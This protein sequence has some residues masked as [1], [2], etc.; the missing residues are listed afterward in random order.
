MSTGE[1]RK[2][3]LHTS[4]LLRSLCILDTDSTI[5][6]SGLVTYCV[7]SDPL[8]WSRPAAGPE[9]HYGLLTLLPG[10]FLRLSTLERGSSGP[11]SRFQSRPRQD[12]CMRP[13]RRLP[14]F[15]WG[16][17]GGNWIKVHYQSVASLGST[18]KFYFLNCYLLILILHVLLQSK[19]WYWY[20]HLSPYL[21]VYLLL[22][23]LIDLGNSL[24]EEKNDLYEME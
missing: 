15:P 23:L 22:S 2:P 6:R 7:M 18:K 5:P 11:S 10:A 17:W 16:G 20:H 24:C 3:C 4:R 19:I 21:C 13:V 12:D 8:R 1:R 14:V 9:W